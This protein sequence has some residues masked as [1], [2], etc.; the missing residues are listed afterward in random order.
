MKSVVLRPLAVFTITFY[1]FGCV[2]F[3]ADTTVRVVS[4]VIFF[5]LSVLATAAKLFLG[6]KRRGIIAKKTAT[7]AIL[8]ALSAFISCSYSFVFF[9]L[10][11]AG[12]ERLAASTVEVEATV[13][14]V[15]WDGGYRGLYIAATD[16]PERMSFVLDTV[17]G[18]EAGSIVKG[19]MTFSALEEDGDF[20]ESRYYMSR[21]VVLKARAEEISVNGKAGLTPEGI[22]RGIRDRLSKIFT[23]HMGKEEGGFA[24]ALL[25]GDD[26]YLSDEVSR[27]FRRLGIVHVLAISGMHLTVLCAFVSKLTEFLG[28]KAQYIACIL[29]VVFYLFITGF[30]GAV[31]RSAVMVIFMIAA[32]FL[33]RGSDGFTNLGISAFLITAFDPYAFADVGL[34]LSFCAVMA[35]FLYSDKRQ[36]LQKGMVERDLKEKRGILGTIKNAALSFWEGMVLTVIVVMFMLPLEWYYFGELSIISP[37]TSPL[38]SMVGDVLLWGL[39]ILLVLSPAKTMASALAYLLRHLISFICGVANYLSHI[40]NVSISLNYPLAGAFSIA[41]ML[42]VIAFCVLKG[43][44]RLVSLL[45]SLC[46][47]AGYAGFC[48]TVALPDQYRAGIIP[49]EYKSNDGML[50]SSDGKAALCDVG[51]GYSG[52]LDNGIYGMDEFRKTEL[53]ALVLTHLHRAYVSSVETALQNVIIRKVYIPEGGELGE[54]LLSLCSQ[55]GAEGIIYKYGSVIPLGDAEIRV[56]EP[57]YIERSAQPVISLSVSAFEEEFVYLGAAFREAGGKVPIDAEY[58]WYGD[59]G[60]KYKSNFYVGSAKVFASDTAMEYA[61]GEYLPA[62]WVDRLYLG[63]SEEKVILNDHQYEG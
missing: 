49:L 55:Y 17:G 37:V 6:R 32:S 57:L 47:V 25:F 41:V 18:I 29:T 53:E 11:Q 30:S 19:K 27:D 8:L 13:T 46:L 33:G 62:Y 9:D 36:K 56:E 3:T 5:V 48:Y 16:E 7:A 4:A 63:K 60:P 2:M 34:Q 28:K 24:A 59:H 42:L 43:K 50:I 54:A 10:V 12:Y 40:K 15:V 51:N 14:E 35:I 23:D 44:K 20:N 31:T 58:I 45:I 1:I 21:G 22:A 52:I 26:K 38:F 61:V 39:P